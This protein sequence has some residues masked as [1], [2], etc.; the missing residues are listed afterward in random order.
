MYTTIV[1]AVFFLF[2]ETTEIV[3]NRMIKQNIKTQLIIT[4]R[5]Y[6][7]APGVRAG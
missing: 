5:C 3:S 1:A 7:G 6:R 2:R 4:D